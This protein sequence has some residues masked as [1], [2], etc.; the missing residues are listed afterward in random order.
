MGSAASLL[1]SPPCVEDS[2]VDVAVDAHSDYILGK[3]ALF[4][5]MLI[6]W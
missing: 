3:Y 4:S 1:P 6:A 2:L 5:S